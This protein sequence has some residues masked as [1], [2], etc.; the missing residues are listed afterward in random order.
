MVGPVSRAPFS[1]RGVMQEAY[2]DITP[3]WD[4]NKQASR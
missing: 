1:A 4:G 3:A 2:P